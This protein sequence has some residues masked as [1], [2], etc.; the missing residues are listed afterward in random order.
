MHVFKNIFIITRSSS[1]IYNKLAGVLNR[2]KTSTKEHQELHGSG[3]HQISI[4]RT[5]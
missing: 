3:P 1:V 4:L 5:L 2:S